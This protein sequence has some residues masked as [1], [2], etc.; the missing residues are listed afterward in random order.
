MGEYEVLAEYLLIVSPEC[1]V[2]KGI[3]NRARYW[4]GQV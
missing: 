1:T 3:D 2:L 4:N